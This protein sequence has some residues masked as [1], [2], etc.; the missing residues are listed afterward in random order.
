MTPPPVAEI[1]AF[2]VPVAAE[3]DAES[4]RVLPLVLPEGML[5]G[6]NVAVTP[7]GNP[8]TDSATAEVKPFNAPADKLT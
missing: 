3:D 8:D 5:A 7:L 6:E 2:D 1:V 4:V